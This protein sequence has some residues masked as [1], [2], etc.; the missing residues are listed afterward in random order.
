MIYFYSLIGFNVFSIWIW[1]PKENRAKSTKEPVQKDLSKA[2]AGTL[3]WVV[4]LGLTYIEAVG[5]CTR[6]RTQTQPTDMQAGSCAQHVTHLIQ[7]PTH[8]A[9]MSYVDILGVFWDAFGLDFDRI[10]DYVEP[11][12]RRVLNLLIPKLGDYYILV[13]HLILNKMDASNPRILGL[14]Q[15]KKGK[16][17]SL[18]QEIVQQ[19]IQRSTRV[20]Q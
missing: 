1:P 16:G 20:V 10:L 17:S 2:H 18:P 7:P 9:T 13:N 8:V 4:P 11:N 15:D 6:L 3:S 5:S 19:S 12:L 14:Q